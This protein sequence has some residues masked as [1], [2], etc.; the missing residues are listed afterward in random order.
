MTDKRHSVLSPSSSSR[1]LNCP[2]SVVLSKDM[3]DEASPYAQEGTLAHTVAEQS[4]CCVR[5]GRYP[6]NTLAV[7]LGGDAEMQAAADEYAHVLMSIKHSGDKVQVFEIECP[8]SLDAVTGE[9][10]SMGTADCVIVVD[11]VL[12]VVDFKYGR[13]VKVEAERNTQLGIYALA[14]IERFKAH[15][16]RAVALHIVQPRI[17]HYARWDLTTEELGYFGEAVA[18]RAHL[19]LSLYTGQVAVSDEHFE[20]NTDTCRF[21]KA[22][23]KCP[24]FT[25]TARNAVVESFPDLTERESR[26]LSA[27][28]VVPN[29]PALLAK[30]FGAADMIE[31][32]VKTVRD[33]MLRRLELGEAIPG[34]KLVAG[35]PGNRKWRDEK[36]AEALL[37]RM[38]VHSGSM[39]EK[40]IVSPTKAERLVKASE[41]G[42][43]QWRKLEALI[44]RPDGKPVVAPESDP[45]AA[46]KLDAVDVFENLEE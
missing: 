1:W 22:K 44:E 46:L 23:T 32:W 43:F 36:E 10:D 18:E 12:H 25:A 41:L 35:R 34:F 19:A 7:S 5:T 20:A 26:D 6:D 42:R 16:I 28:L 37:K 17:K 31:L 11:D 24:K 33:S 2:A 4:A 29:D 3:P 9:A 39:Y 14:A 30:A 15:A 13:G 8:L 45:R 38:R 40:K 27:V 21:C